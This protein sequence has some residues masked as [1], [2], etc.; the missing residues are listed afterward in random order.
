MHSI[1]RATMLHIIFVG[2]HPFIDG[3]GRDSRLLLNLDLMK[4]GLPP[5]VIK[6]ENR[7]SYYDALDKAHTTG[8][9]GDL[10]ELVKNEVEQTLDW[11]LS[12]T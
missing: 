9:Y 8:I 6:T 10:I 2:I 1:E 7:L 4:E 3:N 5:I 12:M 11:Y